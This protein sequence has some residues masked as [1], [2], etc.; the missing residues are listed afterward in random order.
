MAVEAVLDRQSGASADSANTATLRMRRE[1]IVDQCRAYIDET[2]K[3]K[4]IAGEQ[5]TRELERWIEKQGATTEGV[6]SLHEFYE[7]FLLKQLATG[8]ELHDEFYRQMGTARSND[9][10]T[11]KSF[12]KW[13]ARFKDKKAGFKTREEWV[14]NQLPKY[15]EAWKASAE[16]RKTLIADKRF[17]DLISFDPSF[18]VIKDKDKFMDLHFDKRVGL[19]A[20]ARAALKASNRLQIDVYS[21]AKSKL[22]G[23]VSGEFLSHAKAGKWLE[24]LFESTMNPKKV[25]AFV[26]G[27]GTNSLSNHIIDWFNVKKRFDSVIGKAKELGD[28][29]A[30]RGFK[31]IS[32]HEFLSMEYP[33]RMRYVQQAEE[34]MGDAKNVNEEQPVILKIR[35]AM[36]MKDWPDAMML[37]QE[38]KTMHLKGND[39]TRLAFM[40]RYTEK[41]MPK[42]QDKDKMKDV[43]AARKRLDHLVEHMQKSHSEVTPMVLRL[44]KSPHA[45]RNIHQLRWITY[46]NLWCRTHGPPYLDDAKARKGA[47]EDNEQLT[48]HRA[49]NGLDVG[50]HDVL[51]YETSDKNYFRK[52]EHSRNKATFLHANVKS[53]GVLSTVAEKMEHEQHPSWCYWTTLNFHEDGDPKSA[54]WHQ[55]LLMMLTEMRSLSRTINGAGFMYRGLNE[56]MDSLN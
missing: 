43:T 5:E 54:Q 6:R 34:R 51:D 9:W 47:S 26:N 28:N 17:D 39:R 19:L 32:A 46:N 16:A 42:S 21:K 52:N 37:I 11:E 29:D 25:E 4:G 7:G 41:H 53:G 10:I 56:R 27:T 22:D 2:F 12:N 31:M 38:A 30:A 36:D 45:N 49:E 18:A 8:R 14:K 1:H 24:R 33:A 55:E 13:V 35:H 48:K 3:E 20:T 40:E 50:R 44:L 15:A 23:A